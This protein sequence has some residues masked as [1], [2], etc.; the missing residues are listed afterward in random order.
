MAAKPQ[1]AIFLV[2]ILLKA[3]FAIGECA[4]GVA[5][6]FATPDTLSRVA[7]FL[8]H[9]KLV[10]NPRDELERFIQRA[11]QDLNV[12]GHGFVGIYLFFH[13]LVK[14]GVVA[15]LL[16]GR[17]WAYPTAIIALG[18]FIVYQLTRYAYTHAPALLL[19]SLFDAF[20]IFM[21]WREYEAKKIEK[22]WK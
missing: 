3:L 6:Y 16:S 13:G 8:L 2:S 19:I 20:I 22:G 17:R 18:L 5:M 7:H 9:N 15:A 21:V 1:H 12:S 11:L 14:I 4:S 10:A